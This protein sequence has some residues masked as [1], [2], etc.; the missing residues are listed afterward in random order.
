MAMAGRG[1]FPFRSTALDRRLLYKTLTVRDAT[2]AQPLVWGDWFFEAA[3]GSLSL[4][5]TGVLS[6]GDT[7]FAPA[8]GLNL[9]VK[10]AGFISDGDTLFAPAVG[11]NLQPNLFSDGDTLFAP[12]VSAA[13]AVQSLQKPKTKLRIS[14][15]RQV[16]DIY[17]N[18]RFKVEVQFPGGRT[19]L[20]AKVAT[21]QRAFSA[22]LVAAAPQT[23]ATA[24]GGG[25]NYTPDP[26]GASSPAWQNNPDYAIV[27]QQ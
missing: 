6:D 18:R 2:G 10:L 16:R 14:V 13:P 1:D 19:I 11:L 7:L 8:I 26:E 23:S 17:L 20:K 15:S 9:N 22:A 12:V 25:G 5:F 21:R 27:N 24:A 4:V 3:S